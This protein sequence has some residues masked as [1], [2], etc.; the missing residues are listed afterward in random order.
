M[1]TMVGMQNGRIKKNRLE[2]SRN[3]D[4]TDMKKLLCS[5]VGG[6]KERKKQKDLKD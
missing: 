4:I 2:N 5:C 1:K 6:V 3:T